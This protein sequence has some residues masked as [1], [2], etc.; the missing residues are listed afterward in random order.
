MVQF[1]RATSNEVMDVD[2]TTLW[3]STMEK[4]SYIAW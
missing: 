2:D 3:S 1:I 4:F